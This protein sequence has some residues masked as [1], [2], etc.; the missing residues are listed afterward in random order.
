MSKDDL[1]FHLKCFPSSTED[2]EMSLGE[3]RLCRQVLGSLPQLPFPLHDVPC[4]DGT[5]QKEYVIP[6][7]CREEVLNQLCFLVPVPKMDDVMFD[8]HE[9][10]LFT[11]R[12]FRVIRWHGT[13]I[14]ASPYFDHTGGMLVDW[15]EPDNLEESVHT[16]KKKG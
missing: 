6:M 3:K 4:A 16:I 15:M 14:L 13:N 1:E 9:Q 11:V 12:D 7:E 5:I 10:K 2:G 8:L